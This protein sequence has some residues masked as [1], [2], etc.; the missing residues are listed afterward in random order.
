VTRTEERF[1]VAVVG[2]GP[3][4]LAAA[5]AA[6]EQGLSAIV[7]ERGTF[8][9]D[10]AC[11]E[12]LLPPGVRALEH[13]GVLRHI[14]PS[15]CRRFGGIR[16]LQED[17][18][19]AAAPL[20]AGG[21]LGIRRTALLLALARRASEVGVVVRSHLAVRG[22]EKDTAAAFVTTD[23]GIVRADVV[24]AADGLHSPIR[25]AAG[26]D[27]RRAKRRR[28]ALRRHWQ[29]RP[30]TDHVEVYVDSLGEAVV[31]PVGESA[32]N[33]NFVWEDGEVDDPTIERLASRFPRLAARLANA[34]HLSEVRGA[35]PMGR[36]VVRRTA[37]RLALVGDAA[38][39]VDSISADGLS[40]AFNSA[41]L[42]GRELPGAIARGA[43]AAS[44]A[45]YERAARALFRSYWA[46]TNGLLWIA[47]H[48][49]FRSALIH[50]LERHPAVC[51]AMMGGAMK[52]MLAAAPT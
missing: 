17:D 49:R 27:G 41:I 45:R 3:A 33:V 19:S 21:G 15:S 22:V 34:P 30:W 16:F 8:P 50:R 39:F 5:I 10:K 37:D 47:R 28:F 36:S 46:V 18:A 44:F 12:G 20:P 43:T 2:G 42:L 13:L 52:L 11:G 32:I 51:E 29:I 26:L 38:G 14:D 48:P 35:G 24:I 31:T 1:H 23:S 7:L 9:P 6:A 25:R 40:I 4:G